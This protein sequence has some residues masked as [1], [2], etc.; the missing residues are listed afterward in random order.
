MN[1]PFDLTED[2]QSTEECF[3]GG[4]SKWRQRTEH[5]PGK[6]L[7]TT[8]CSGYEKLVTPTSDFL[9]SRK[10]ACGEMGFPCGF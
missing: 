4:S 3:F 2:P 10:K 8:R 9:I 7:S 5:F 1:S 6:K